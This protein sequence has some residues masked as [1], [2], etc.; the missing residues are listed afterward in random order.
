MIAIISGASSGIGREFAYQLDSMGYDE[1]WLIARRA[2]RLEA[3]AGELRTPAKILG[4]DLC[5]DK[6]YDIIK[7]ELAKAKLKIGILIN[8]AGIGVNDYFDKTS[9][10]D[11]DSMVDLNIK[12]TTRL[13]K[14]SL[15]HMADES[16]I[17]NVASVAGFIPQ[18]KFS[19][20]AASKAY[21]ISL[22][23]SLNRELKPQGI[24]VTA[25]CPNPVDTEFGDTH[26]KG[27]KKYATEDLGKLVTRALLN[28]RKTDL[29]TTH[30]PAKLMFIVSKIIPHSFIMWIEKMLGMY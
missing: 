1:L 29:I 11:L 14:L 7:D 27:I 21:I 9:L 28:S 25:L 24:H 15:S 3:L 10:I 2:D 23:R 8:S 12:A 13:I 19:T 22:T 16:V 20:Y 5:Y 4:L 26:K 18:P 6:S 30:G 17:I